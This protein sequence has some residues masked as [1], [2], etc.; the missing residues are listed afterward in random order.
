MADDTQH[1]IIDDFTEDEEIKSESN[2]WDYKSKDATI[3]G[4][5]TQISDGRYGKDIT[6]DLGGD[7]RKVLPSLTAL[8]TKLANIELQDKVKVISLGEV[9]AASGKTYY[10]FKVFIKKHDQTELD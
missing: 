4:I 8:N 5:V 1:I 10:D 3:F 2:L 9:K 7:E 6:V